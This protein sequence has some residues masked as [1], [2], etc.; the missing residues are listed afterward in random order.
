MIHALYDVFTANAKCLKTNKSIHLNY[1]NNWF[2]FFM[3]NL[4]VLYIVHD[5]NKLLPSMCTVAECI[6]M[7]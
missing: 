7:L 3:I 4:K 6:S 1:E 2:F 5:F